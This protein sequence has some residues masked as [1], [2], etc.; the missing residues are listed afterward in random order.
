MISVIM[1][2]YNGE[3]YLR[4]AIESILNQTYANF[5][6][7]CIDD[8]STDNTLRILDEYSAIDDRIV[9]ISRENK[10]LIATLNEG[11]LRSKYNFIARMDADDI[12]LPSRF[13]KQINYLVSHENVGVVGSSYIYIDQERHVLGVRRLWNIN[14]VLKAICIFGAPF[15]H[16]SVMFNKSALGNELYYSYE[17]KHAEDYE[18]WTRLEK[19]TKFAVLKEPLLKYRVLQTS[20]SRKNKMEQ[21]KNMV[22]A[23]CNNLLVRHPKSIDSV[24]SFYLDGKIN[25][26]FIRFIFLQKRISNIFIQLCYLFVRYIKWKA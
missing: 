24:L 10:G 18:L 15:A 1:P 4:E 21:K 11:I 23:A 7:I 9:I 16:P 19:I 3:L 12:S 8:G 25:I 6:L 14:Y 20:V 2:I 22:I 5:E 17:Y 26:D 13:E